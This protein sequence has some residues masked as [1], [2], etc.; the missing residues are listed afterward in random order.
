MSHFTNSNSDN[1]PVY[2]SSLKVDTPYTPLHRSTA[3][4][5]VVLKTDY[6]AQLRNVS[7]AFVIFFAFMALG[8]VTA[9]HASWLTAGCMIGAFVSVGGAFL[10]HLV[11]YEALWLERLTEDCKGISV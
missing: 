7:A 8:S 11:Q 2:R 10:A 3:S 6:A 5:K 4:P 1:K 9:G